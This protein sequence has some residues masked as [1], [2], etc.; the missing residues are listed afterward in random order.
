MKRKFFYKISTVNHRVNE[1]MYCFCK[2]GEVF[3]KWTLLLE[4]A[5]EN[6]IILLQTFCAHKKDKISPQ[7]NRFL[8]LV[9]SSAK[10]SFVFRNNK[11]SLRKTCSACLNWYSAAGWSWILILGRSLPATTERVTAALRVVVAMYSNSTTLP[12]LLTHSSC[13]F[14]FYCAAVQWHSSPFWVS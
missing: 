1:N 11:Q 7:I 13:F 3:D 9:K 4:L 2:I 8:L 5:N 10:T 6:F 12:L 14:F